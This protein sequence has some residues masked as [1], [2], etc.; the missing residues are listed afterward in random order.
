MNPVN[1]RRRNLAIIV[2]IMVILAVAIYFFLPSKPSFHSI[3]TKKTDPKEPVKQEEFRDASY[4]ENGKWYGLCKKN[5]VH[6]IADF[7]K[8]VEEDPVLKAHFADFKWENAKMGRLEKAIRAYVYYRK[9]DTIFRK[10]TPILLP[11]GDQYI[12]DGNT[13]V[14]TSCCNSYAF[15]PPTYETKDLDAEPSAGAPPP[16]DGTPSHTPSHA[17]SSP[18]ESILN[19]SPETMVG[20]PVMFAPTAQGPIL[21]DHTYEKHDNPKKKPPPTPI[22]PTV[23]LFGTG[24]A[25]LIGFRKRGK[26]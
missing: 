8:T 5:S 7:R 6:S 15:A 22:G 1:R 17:Q 26:K 16:K 21:S 25:V 10:K 20:G 3:T 19:P 18:P 11:R 13:R 24:L 23:W 4:E 9:G 14:R 12:T 2:L